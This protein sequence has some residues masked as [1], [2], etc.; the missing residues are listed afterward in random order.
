MV[1]QKACMDK[2]KFTAC[3]HFT[4]KPVHVPEVL[5]KSACFRKLCSTFG[6]PAD[7]QKPRCLFFQQ[8]C[9]RLGSGHSWAAAAGAQLG[10]D[11]FGSAFL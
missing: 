1:N 2:P 11:L 3:M 4:L 6:K 5:V 10:H 8:L 9:W 7:G